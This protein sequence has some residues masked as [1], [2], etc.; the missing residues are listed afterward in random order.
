[1]K[2]AITPFLPKEGLIA[3]YLYFIKGG[4]ECPRFQF[5][6]FVAIVGSVVKRNIFFQR[7]SN[8][9]FPPIFP[10]MWVILVAP[11]GV[12]KKS[13]SLRTARNMLND[14]QPNL[15]PRILASKL[16]PEA[17]VKALASPMIKEEV[18]KEVPIETAGIIRKEAQGLMYS[19]EFGVLLGKE[20]Y[21]MGIIA[22]L[23]DL[24]DCPEE[25]NSETILHGDQRLY[26]C[27]L[28][29]MGASTPDWL[30][31]MLPSDAFKGGFMSRLLLVSYPQD[32]YMRV[33][34][35]PAP[36]IEYYERITLGL[37]NIARIKGQML[38]TP[39]SKEYFE[40]WYNHLGAPEPGP[41]AQYL[42]RKQ[43]HLIRLAM[44]LQICQEPKL[45]LELKYLQQALNILNAIEPETLQM[46]DYISVEPQMRAVQRILEIMYAFKKISEHE[47]LD[48]VWKHLK[49]PKDFDDIMLML[50]KQ[51]KVKPDTINGEMWYI[52]NE[53]E[54]QK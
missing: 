30:Q 20:K 41:K 44:I 53:K 6:P 48:R 12:G 42:E 27:C 26:N 14:L 8:I 13:S 29:I 35:P 28:T 11:Q 5:F 16:T 21:N 31:S 4:E 43:D 22:L 15:K 40:Y 24:Y 49:R 1:M 47:L 45:V 25:W 38:W 23:T 46:I 36:P 33:A 50:M 37:N 17:L 39:E 54:E 9:T 3:D 2:D 10:S 52:L 7:A 32:W 18:L 51:K 19:S 34:D